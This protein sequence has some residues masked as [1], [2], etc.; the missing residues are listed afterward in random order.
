M[1]GFA[2]IGLYYP[3]DSNN[4]GAVLRAG[5]CYDV[6]MI[7]IQGKRYRKSNVDT[8]KEYRHTPFLEVENL[9]DIIPRDTIPIAVDLL[10]DAIALPNYKH[11]ERGFYIFGPEDGTLGDKV[12]SW[13]RDK[14]Y[15]PTN[16]CMNL[17]ATVNVILYDRLMK[18]YSRE[19]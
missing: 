17:A 19:Y 14:I 8:R 18:S 5:G 3:K 15:V 2:C 9:K 6:S 16:G 13:C 11:P 7:A 10:D 1:R 12:T 4:I